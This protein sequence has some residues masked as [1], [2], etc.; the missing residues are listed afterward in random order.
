MSGFGPR[1]GKP[2]VS[3]REIWLDRGCSVGAIIDNPRGD[4]IVAHNVWRVLFDARSFHALD[5][6]LSSL[7]PACEGP[8][9]Q[10]PGKA[11]RRV[12]S[13]ERIAE[14]RARVAT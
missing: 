3:N 5:V 9:G 13:A 1:P 2:G 6:E 14:Y 12:R 11:E 10:I 8:D 7:D 4:G